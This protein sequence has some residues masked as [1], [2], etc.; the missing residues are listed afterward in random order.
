MLIICTQSGKKPFSGTWW[1]LTE[2]PNHL[3]HQ[4]LFTSRL[5]TPVSLVLPS[6]N[7]S[8][9]FFYYYYYYHYLFLFLI[10][11]FLICCVFCFSYL[12]YHLSVV[13][14]HNRDF[15]WVLLFAFSDGIGRRKMVKFCCVCQVVVFIWVLDER[16]INHYCQKAWSS[17]VH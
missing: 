2:G 3:L 13:F 7:N 14:K 4:S 16:M 11:L 10:L 15:E 9:R 17:L 12:Y 1:S 8:T 6:L 5:S